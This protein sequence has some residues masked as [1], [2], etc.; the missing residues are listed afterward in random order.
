MKKKEKNHSFRKF[1]IILVLIIGMLVIYAKYIGTKGL[2]I[3]ERSIINE[4]IPNSFN[5]YKIVHFSDL[6]YGSSVDIKVL[7]ELVKKVNDLK[8]DI[9]IFT[10]GLLSNDKNITDDEKETLINSLNKLNPNKGVYAVR[11]DEDLTDNYKDIIEKTSINLLKNNV[12]NIYNNDY[13][14]INLIGLD[15]DVDK[16][17]LDNID[18]STYN[19]LLTHKPD[20][21]EKINNDVI[22][23]SLAG[24][25]L[26]GQIRL[27]FI[28]A[29]I[30]Y[31][32]SKHY[33]D[34]F[35][36]NNNNEIYI[37]SG[38][39]TK[40]IPFRLFNHP[41]INFFRLYNN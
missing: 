13:S 24:H 15:E 22:N 35:Y 18:N 29:L 21:I 19:I 12:L 23:L 34:F 26:N 41:S 16:T 10:G 31:D 8:P 4:K 32:G 14:Y 28:G 1:F 3:N 27:P 30:K 25:S 9:I 38:L 36:K 5:G 40:N 20:N 33:F 6:L 2:I 17:I 11:A 7:D 37:S 39:G